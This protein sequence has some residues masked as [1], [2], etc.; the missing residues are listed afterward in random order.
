[1]TCK[2]LRVKKTK[3]MQWWKTG[4]EKPKEVKHTITLKT[5][6]VDKPTNSAF[7]FK[8]TSFFMPNYN[9]TA[10][11]IETENKTPSEPHKQVK[12]DISPFISSSQ[13]NISEDSIITNLNKKEFYRKVK[14]EPPRRK[15]KQLRTIKEDSSDT[16]EIVKHRSRSRSD[17]FDYSIDAYQEFVKNHY[18]VLKRTRENKEEFL[19]KTNESGICQWMS[20]VDLKAISEGKVLI[21]EFKKYDLKEEELQPEEKAVPIAFR[22][23]NELLFRIF[24]D[25]FYWEAVSDE[26][27][28]NFVNSRKNFQFNNKN[29]I[30]NIDNIPESLAKLINIHNEGHS[31][32][33]FD[34]FSTEKYETIGNFLKLLSENNRGPYLIVTNSKN[35]SKFFTY[36][37]KSLNIIDYSC[38]PLERKIMQEFCFNAMDS[39]GISIPNSFTYNLVITTFGILKYDMKWFEKIDFDK[40]I[41]DEPDFDDE[42]DFNLYSNVLFC[43]K[44]LELQKNSTYSNLVSLISNNSEISPAEFS[45]Y[46]I[47]VPRT[48]TSEI[49]DTVIVINPTQYQNDCLRLHSMDLI[50]QITN[51]YTNKSDDQIVSEI[52]NNPMQIRGFEVYYGNI[53]NADLTQIAL[54]LSA[55]FQFINYIVNDVYQDS[56]IMIFTKTTQNMTNLYNLINETRKTFKIYSSFAPEKIDSIIKAASQEKCV[57]ISNFSKIDY[58]L[59]FVSVVIFLEL[60]ENYRDI[61]NNISN[62][63]SIDN[64]HVFHLISS[65]FEIDELFKIKDRRMMKEK[66]ISAEP[67]KTFTDSLD[68][69]LPNVINSIHQYS[70]VK[71]EDIKYNEP[72]MTENDTDFITRMSFNIKKNKNEGLMSVDES[73]LCAYFLNLFG[74]GQW[75]DIGVSINASLPQVKDFCITLI[76]YCLTKLSESQIYDLPHLLSIMKKLII[77]FDV[78]DI[79]EV[80]LDFKLL[81]LARNSFHALWINEYRF[82]KTI[83]M[84]IAAKT[85]LDIQ[86]R[87]A[88]DYKRDIDEYEIS[89]KVKKKSLELPKDFKIAGFEPSQPEIQILKDLVFGSA[90]DPLS[91]QS[92]YIDEMMNR[93]FAEQNKVVFEMKWNQC[94]VFRITNALKE[95]PNDEKFYDKLALVTKTREQVN[96][97]VEEIL[98]KNVN[99]KVILK[100][101]NLKV[102][103]KSE[104]P[105]VSSKNDIEK[106]QKMFSLMK[107]FINREERPVTE[108]W[109]DYHTAKY[110]ELILHLG[111]HRYREILVDSRFP[112]V[113]LLNLEELRYIRKRSKTIPPSSHDFV[114]SIK[115]M[116]KF[117]GMESE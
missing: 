93:K 87:P 25:Y 10:F 69:D 40:V 63:S 92:L 112:F 115:G 41:Y 113:S 12:K 23:N 116:Q 50:P 74:F 48:F 91:S 53:F 84:R 44:S 9:K 35:Y 79:K 18:I 5:E 96:K 88:F 111:L 29:K 31:A 110:F 15:R 66:Y 75:R 86:E 97:K 90:I 59:S 17:D 54:K 99:R 4:G 100:T 61:I 71:I 3:I 39:N 103:P 105:N 34:E 58:D 45:K 7:N 51:H 27:Y 16:E 83:D 36:L 76:N 104:T 47:S 102:P 89:G 13:F 62:P 49:S 28:N 19:I 8:P 64:C 42:F 82:L 106:Y 78:E 57:I 108:E 65:K 55:K 21:A 33:L 32:I 46:V 11:S 6:K 80:D 14:N 43:L 73:F 81:R 85:F 107:D 95:F 77:D 56:T 114:F 60:E 30:E 37:P 38:D 52:L 2:K 22:P 1:M 72:E 67:L 68:L 26:E 98:S 117:L 24:Y 94:E 109:S 70:T 101:D 20:L